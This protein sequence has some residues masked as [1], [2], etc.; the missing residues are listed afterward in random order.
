MT[1]PSVVV[2]REASNEAMDAALSALPEHYR[3]AIHGRLWEN[4]SFGEIG[5][6]LGISDDCAQKLFGRAVAK[7]RERLG[8]GHDLG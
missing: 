7:L 1:P 2:Q 5:S 8:P 3:A 6:R 4:L